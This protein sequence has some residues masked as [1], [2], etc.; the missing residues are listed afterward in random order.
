MKIRND[1]HSYGQGYFDGMAV[2]KIEI[3]LFVWLVMFLQEING[4]QQ[5]EKAT[6][7]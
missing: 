3:R 4:K 7:A 6:K 2:A 1:R 5:Q